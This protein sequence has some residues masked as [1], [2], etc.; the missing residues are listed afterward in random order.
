MAVKQWSNKPKRIPEEKLYELTDEI[1]E[2]IE[3]YSRSTEDILE[4]ANFMEKYHNYSYRNAMLIEQQWTGATAVASYQRWKELGVNVKEKAKI[5]IL[6]PVEYT[7][8]TRKDGTTSTLKNA[9]PKEKKMIERG[10]LETTKRRTFKTGYVFDITQTD[11]KIEDLPKLFPNRH[12]NFE[13]DNDNVRLLNEALKEYGTRIGVPILIDKSNVLGNSKGRFS[14]QLDLEGKMIPESQKILLNPR[15]TKSEM[16]SVLVHELVHGTLHNPLYN[17]TFN[18]KETTKAE[19]EFQAELSSYIICK[20]FGIDTSEATIPYI[21]QWTKN[22]QSLKDRETSLALVHKTAKSMISFID[23]SIDTLEQKK[24]QKIVTEK[25]SESSQIV[26]KD[27]SKKNIPE[28]TP[29]KQEKIKL[30][31]EDRSKLIAEAKEI[32]LLDFAQSQG[33]HFKKDGRKTYRSE[34]HSSLLIDV[35]KNL[36]NWNSRSIHGNILQFAEHLCGIKNFDE[37]LLTITNQD[38]KKFEFKERPKIPYVYDYTKES[39]S[40]A[41]AKNYLVNERKIDERLVDVLNHLG[42]IKQDNRGNV[43]FLWKVDN[44]IVGASEQGTVKSDRY[45]R[46]SWKSIQANSSGDEGFSFTIGTPKHLKFFESSIDL[47]SYCSLHSEQKDT[48]YI[49]F[50]G[51]KDSVF[52]SNLKRAVNDLRKLPGENKVESISLCVDND[53]AGKEFL[54]KINKKYE[55][56]D[57]KSELPVKPKEKNNLDKWDWNDALKYQDTQKKQ[58]KKQHKESCL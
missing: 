37:A 39:Q 19:R 30:S 27:E 28:R 13:V 5:G 54:E 11:A 22:N 2:K 57:L 31:I 56:L 32:D 17:E 40:F 48:R 34:E 53:K 58:E 15:N 38:L 3:N 55:W 20:H 18:R 9:T 47:L 46:G 42:Y 36:F 44:K 50:E 43:L 26:S 8:F 45:P 29:E 35:E 51:L 6:T 52:E 7:V 4:M 10:E 21:A 16:V 12:Y 14:Y 25:V 49:S 41:K 1:M 24:E 23:H 33:F